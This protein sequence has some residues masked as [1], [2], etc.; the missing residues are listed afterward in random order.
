ML[1]LYLFG[2]V[3]WRLQ[4]PGYST[5]HYVH[6]EVSEATFL[7][8]VNAQKLSRSGKSQQLQIT[9]LGI[10][11][12]PG[13]LQQLKGSSFCYLPADIKIEIG[14]CILAKGRLDTIAAPAHPGSFNFARYMTLQGMIRQL[15]LTDNSF[16]ILPEDP[17]PSYWTLLKK[18]SSQL[19]QR[20]SQRL[21]GPAAGLVVALVLGQKNQLDSEV[22]EDY[23][24]V[25]AMHV[26]AV[27]G[28]HVGILAMGISYLLSFWTGGRTYIR[29]I[30]GLISVAV[31]W[32]FA[33]LT[34]GAPSVLRAA[35]MF[36]LFSLGKQLYLSQNIWNILAATALL[37]LSAQ[38]R[39][40]F[41]VGFQLS[42]LAVAAIVYFQPK[43]AQIIPV[44]NQV[45]NYFWQLFTLGIAAQLGTAILSIH[46]F[47]QFPVYFWLSGLVIV[48]LATIA[49]LL[50]IS[51]LI[52]ADVPL[53]GSLLAKV[54]QQLVLLMNKAMAWISDLPNSTLQQLQISKELCL[55]LLGLLFLSIL[56][57]EFRSRGLV[58]LIFSV[59]F[60]MG[61]QHYNQQVKWDQ[62]KELLIYR[63]RKQLAFSLVEGQQSLSFYNKKE[64]QNFVSYAKDSYLQYKNIRKDS[65]V[66]LNHSSGLIQWNNQQ[67]LVLQDRVDLCQLSLSSK[68]DIAILAA[69]FHCAEPNLLKD[70]DIGIF[71]LHPGLNR[72]ARLY[73]QK[74]LSEKGAVIAGIGTSEAYHLDF[75]Y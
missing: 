35:T 56:W 62:Q 41:T 70:Q 69:N 47:H 66:Y 37:M 49:L 58:Y 34:G 26:L 72:K 55:L 21:S 16:Y 29:L 6:T 44:K 7:F 43:L 8:R 73:W 64:D 25:G 40:I 10:E 52:L 18:I 5:Q 31:I 30:K 54:L 19:Q 50:G 20:L 24:R 2:Q 17:F 63:H 4:T 45:V 39:A 36:S 68:I 23:T 33:L 11:T 42:F 65:S 75:K 67:I 32:V 71:Y 12:Q 3:V 22:R 13:V 27:S 15:R 9:I 57:I 28:M 38:S 1:L 46:Y 61:I 60:L 51:V 59:T 53:L 48:P 14:A 74:K